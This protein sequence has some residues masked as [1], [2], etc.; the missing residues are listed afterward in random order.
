MRHVNIDGDVICYAVGFAGETSLYFDKNDVG[1]SG[2]REAINAGVDPDDL[3]KVT[4]AEPVHYVLSTA[5]RMIA[6]I[7][8]ACEADT[9]NVI[10]TGKGNFREKVATLQPY[11]GNRSQPK[12]LLHAEIREYITKY[13]NAV[14]VDGEEADDYLAYSAVA[15]G[16]IIATIDK[17]LLNVAGLHYNWNK[18][19]DGVFNVTQREASVNFYTQLLTGD[20][21]DNIPGLFRLTGQRA[22]AVLK[23]AVSEADDELGMY[24]IVLD[25]YADSLMVQGEAYDAAYT[26]AEE[27]LAEIGQLLWMRHT[28]NETWTPPT[29]NE[30]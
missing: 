30:L 28:P 9:Y 2:K 18:P 14:T 3:T 29:G 12:P 10:L 6:N 16:D 1:Y 8:K 27:M 7:V 4:T 11:K 19:D 23:K 13:Q 25:V 21:T 15:S 20:A 17:D 5:K 24:A 26:K 22:T